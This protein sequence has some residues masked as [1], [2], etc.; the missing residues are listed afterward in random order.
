MDF[1]KLTDKSVEEI[2]VCMDYSFLPA[3]IIH[4][5]TDKK[6]KKYLIHVFSMVMLVVAII[7]RILGM[8]YPAPV[9]VFWY[10]YIWF[11]YG[12]I[13]AGMLFVSIRLAEE[14]EL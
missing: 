14:K 8:E 1:S 13:V 2:A 7:M 9:L 11:V 12:I 3:T 10:F 4:L 5:I 6:D